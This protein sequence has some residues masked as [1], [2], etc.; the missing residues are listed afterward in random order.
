MSAPTLAAFADAGGA[1]GQ[2][3]LVHDTGHVEHHDVTRWLRDAD[4]D[5]LRLIDR[6]DGPALDVGCGPGRLT[7]ALA[8]RQ[9]PALG[10]DV[11]AR[12]VAMTRARGACAIRRDVFA[13]LPGTGRWQWVVLADGNIGIGG[14]PERLL[15]RLAHLVCPGG[16]A[17]VEVS[18]L[19]IDHRGSGRM[20]RPDGSVGSAFPW[21]V[22]GARAVAA[23]TLGTGWTVAELL[24]AGDRR[25]VV[26]RRR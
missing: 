14:N 9:I 2:V 23:A 11:C 19:D 16:G 17:V 7:S 8:L 1:G 6:C 3:R 10:V 25:S 4:D 20:Q 22:L 12:A 15:R 18:P 13:R 5:D 26:L 24:Q 21:A